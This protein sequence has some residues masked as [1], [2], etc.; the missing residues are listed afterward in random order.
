MED[1]I[2]LMSKPHK[3]T[4]GL[5]STIIGIVVNFLLALIKGVAGVLGN[6]YA[7]IADAIESTS[8]IFSSLIVYFG[9]KISTKP[10][11]ACHPYGHGKAEPIAAILVTIALLVAAII[12]IIQSIKE[13]TNPHGAPE[14]FTLF[15]LVLVV[16]VKESLF[17]FVIKVGT[18]TESTA[19]K[20]DAWHHRSDAI[21]SAAAFVGILIAILGGEGFESADDYAALFASVIIITNAVRLFIPAFNELMDKSPDGRHRDEVIRIT[22]LVPEVIDTEKCFI[23]KMGFDYFVELHIIVDA[24]LTVKEGHEIAH[25]VK[26]KLLKANLDIVDVITHVEPNE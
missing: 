14:V 6:S 17:R 9:L 25:R 13:I 2:F 22:K 21:T 20:T 16:L 4:P 24:N 18:E 12:I 8:D 26:N 5:R 7:L 11:D 15:V 19:V 23:R 10:R 3:A 1:V